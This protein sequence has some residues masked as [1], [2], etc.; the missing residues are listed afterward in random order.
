MVS[1]ARNELFVRIGPGTPMGELLRRYW[2]PVAAASEF[3]GEQRVRSVRLL[4]EDLVMFKDFSGHYGLVERRCAHRGADLSYGIVEDHGLRCQ[5]HG[6]HYDRDGRCLAQPYE[7]TVDPQNAARR[8]VRL[9]HYRAEEKAGLVWA[10]MGP[11]PAPLVPA[12][13]PFTWEHGFRQIVFADVPCN[14]F[15]CQENSVDPVHFEWMHENWTMR[16]KGDRGA[17]T[18][19]HIRLKFEEFEYGL[20]Y[21]RLREGASEDN[22][23][24]TVGRVALWPNAFF[25][26]S[27]FEWRVPVDDENTLSIVWCFDRVPRE[28]EPYLQRRIPHWYAPIKDEAT[29]RWITS[30]VINQDIVAWVGQGTIADRTRETPGRSDEGVMLMRKRLLRDLKAV[31]RGQDPSALVRD[32]ADGPIALPCANREWQIR[33]RSLEQMLTD[34]L[35]RARLADFPFLAGQPREVRSEFEQAM[36]LAEISDRFTA[37]G[38]AGLVEGGPAMGQ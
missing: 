34:K 30:H 32:A 23:L 3:D 8:T 31:E 4:G 15:Q 35:T 2:H 26:G 33:G 21:K 38:A 28:R 9:T 25:L 7:D 18:A 22:P 37:K 13:E 20:I 27:H 14:W 6:W 19:P 17:Y 10:Y 29:G 1:E 5:Y 24:W 12:W 11:E 16:L 36:G